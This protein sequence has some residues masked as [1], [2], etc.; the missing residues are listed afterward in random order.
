MWTVDH[1]K[2]V[3][4]ASVRYELCVNNQYGTSPAQWYEEHGQ[5]PVCDLDAE[6]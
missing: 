6:K 3:E 4:Q 5:Y 1:D 2:K